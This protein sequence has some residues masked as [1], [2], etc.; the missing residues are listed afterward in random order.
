[1]DNSSI[2][3]NCLHYYTN[4]LEQS[5]LDYSKTFM[6]KDKKE[7]TN[8]YQKMLNCWQVVSC[9]LMFQTEL[10]PDMPNDVV[11]LGTWKLYM[12]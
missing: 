11:A 8:L 4:N 3:G 5:Y 10:P 12:G 1:M 6:N 9:M 7:M 2:S